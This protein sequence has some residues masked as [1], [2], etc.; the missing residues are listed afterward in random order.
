MK[1]E[2]FAI[3]DSKVAAFITPFFSPTVASAI[4]DFTT[5]CNT[6]TSQFNQHAGDYTLF[7]LGTFDHESGKTV[8]L[9]TSVN[10]GLAITFIK[11]DI[12]RPSQMNISDYPRSIQGGE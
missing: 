11:N 8:E 1:S 3:H 5:A 9:Q 12:A 4:R 7:H 10:L 2:K 6:E